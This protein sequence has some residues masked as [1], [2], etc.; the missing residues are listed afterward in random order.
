ML[1]VEGLSKQMCFERSFKCVKLM[2]VLKRDWERIPGVKT[3]KQLSLLC[4]Q[5]MWFARSHNTSEQTT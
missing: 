2:S 5:L 1:K 3:E 4:R